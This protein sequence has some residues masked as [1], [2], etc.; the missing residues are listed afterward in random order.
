MDVLAFFN[1]FSSY[2]EFLKKTLEHQ[3][4]SADNPDASGYSARIRDYLIGSCGN[5]IAA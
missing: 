5:V 2:P 3:M 1:C 4:L